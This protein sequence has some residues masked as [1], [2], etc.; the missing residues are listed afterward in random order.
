MNLAQAA[1]RHER[2][3]VRVGVRERAHGRVVRCR[4]AASGPRTS[5]A[6]TLGLATSSSPRRSRDCPRRPRTG[7]RRTP[8][9][10]RGQAPV[11]AEARLCRPANPGACAPQR[12]RVATRRGRDAGRRP[13]ANRPGGD[14]ARR[15]ARHARG[16]RRMAASHR[17]HVG[18]AAEVRADLEV[19]TLGGRE[20]AVEECSFRARVAPPADRVPQAGQRTHRWRRHCRRRTGRSARRRAP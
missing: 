16:A 13:R 4:T 19:A 14:P 12:D 2:D 15:C 9:R 3:R 5:P 10:P 17:Q 18:V 1:Q 8:S 11:G 7:R 6:G 20:P